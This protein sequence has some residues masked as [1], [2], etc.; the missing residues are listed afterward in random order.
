MNP[1]AK[2]IES[3]ILMRA[4]AH[5]ICALNSADALLNSLAA[6]HQRLQQ[7]R[8]IHASSDVCGAE[9]HASCKDL[10]TRDKLAGKNEG[11]EPLRIS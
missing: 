9:L 5:P 2:T 4:L 10:A 3:T 6:V 8:T 1:S 7:F 11:V